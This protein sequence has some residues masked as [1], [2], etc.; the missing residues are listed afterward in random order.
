M[1][2]TD[3]TLT[4]LTILKPASG[5]PVTAETATAARVSELA[6]TQEAAALVVR[7]FAEHG[8]EVGPLVG[9]SFS[10]TVPAAN[11]A[12]VLGDEV[13]GAFPNAPLPPDARAHV[14]AI[15]RDRP[16]D[17]GPVSFGP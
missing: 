2:A 6:P 10:V 5:R 1:A 7:Y 16:R 8:A 15:V 14:D 13:D 3:E 12:A 11:A 9:N 4:V 17:F